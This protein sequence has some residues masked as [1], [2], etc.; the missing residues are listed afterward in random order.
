MGSINSYRQYRIYFGFDLD[1]GTPSTGI[2]YE[3]PS[4][5]T[6]LFAARQF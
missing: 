6:H 4:P 1:K 3:I 2:V 5:F